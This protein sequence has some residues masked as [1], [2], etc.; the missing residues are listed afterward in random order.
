M[1]EFEYKLALFLLF[2]KVTEKEKDYLRL[3]KERRDKEEGKED[4]FPEDSK[5]CLEKFNALFG[6]KP[7]IPGESEEED[8]KY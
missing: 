3:R 8:Q 2:D 5:K 7:P 6:M 4:S 1:R